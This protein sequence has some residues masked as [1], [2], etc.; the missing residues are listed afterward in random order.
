MRLG[1]RGGYHRE[2][3]KDAQPTHS[4]HTQAAAMGH[5]GGMADLGILY[6]LASKMKDGPPTVTQAGDVAQELDVVSCA[7]CLWGDKI[8]FYFCFVFLF[9]YLFLFFIFIFL[10]M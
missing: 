7:I 6:A 10:L 1:R 9:I 3:N 2:T 5:P 4:N 8:Y